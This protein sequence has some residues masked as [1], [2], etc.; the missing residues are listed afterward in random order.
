MAGSQKGASTFLAE[1]EEFMVRWNY[2]PTIFGRLAASDPNFVPQLR[3]GRQPRLDTADRVRDW[4]KGGARGHG[5][6]GTKRRE[7]SAAAQDGRLKATGETISFVL[8]HALLSLNGRLRQTQKAARRHRIGLA[9]EVMALTAGQ[10]PREPW[11]RAKIIVQRMSVR[12]LDEDNLNASVKTLLDVLQPPS[13]HHPSGL[14][15]IANDS[16]D[17]I[18]LEISATKVARSDLAGTIVTILRLADA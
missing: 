18:V 2:A 12:T 3:E 10:R 7:P 8:P 4:M 1:V 9:K 11:T 5:P 14:G 16:P 17:H 13:A 6:N 15:I